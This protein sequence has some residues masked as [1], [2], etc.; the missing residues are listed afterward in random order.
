V[1]KQYSKTLENIISKY[2]LI[3]Y[4]ALSLLVMGSVLF[5][6]RAYWNSPPPPLNA[7]LTITF[8]LLAIVPLA[9]RRIFLITALIFVTAIFF[10]LDVLNITHEVYFSSIASIIS[11]FSASAYGGN[12]RNLACTASIVFYC[13]G[14]VY[15]L[16]F[17]S[18]IVFLSSATF[19]NVTGLLWNLVTF[20]VIWRLGNTLRLS[21]EQTLELREVTE[22]LV[23]E[24]DMLQHKK[25]TYTVKEIEGNGA[26]QDC[27]P[28]ESTPEAR[29]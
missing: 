16:M 18:N 26:G 8:A 28:P 25:K 3:D 17:S 12:M 15:K 10:A 5:N 21:R 13:G 20:L 6:Q 19:F 24:R 9:R 29:V 4:C 1:N 11:V 22:Q 27:S 23:R 7:P 14:M 2:P